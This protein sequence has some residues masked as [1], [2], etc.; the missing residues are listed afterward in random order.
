MH[1]YSNVL[2]VPAMLREPGI[3]K[4]ELAE[5]LWRDGAQLE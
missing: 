3:G 4:A 1:L 5:L 2:P